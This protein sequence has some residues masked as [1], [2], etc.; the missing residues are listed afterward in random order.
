MES[1]GLSEPPEGVITGDSVPRE[2][3]EGGV[4]ESRIQEMVGI[5]KTKEA[6]RRKSDSELREIAKEKLL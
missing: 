3:E 6:Y 4:E 2:N 1:A 5:M